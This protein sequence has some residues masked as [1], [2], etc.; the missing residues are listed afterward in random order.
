MVFSVYES[1]QGENPFF[2]GNVICDDLECCIESGDCA[3]FEAGLDAYV[4]Q[5]P[6]KPYYIDFLYLQSVEFADGYVWL[7]PTGAFFVR[8]KK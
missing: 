8:G 4:L 6:D 3:E 5:V 7:D 1:D 2:L